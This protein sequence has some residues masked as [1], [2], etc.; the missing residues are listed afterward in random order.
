VA[1]L[2]LWRLPTEGIPT[3]RDLNIGLNINL[4]MEQHDNPYIS[5][6]LAFEFHYFSM[7]KFWFM[8]MAKA[9]VISPGGFG[10]VDELFETMTLITTHKMKKKMPIV[11]F[12][13]SYWDDV[14]NLDAMIE[15]GAISVEEAALIFKIDS[16]DAAFNHI[17]ADL[18]ENALN[19][20]DEV[21]SP[22]MR[23]DS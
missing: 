5:R 9:L 4:P 16:D 10:T 13:S 21:V 1:A 22:E 18:E 17:S 7:R 15:Q 20:P 3:Q 23:S 6:E 12:G 8:F 11:L 19:D 2:E 14:L